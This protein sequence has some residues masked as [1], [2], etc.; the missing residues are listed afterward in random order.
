M[1]KLV[2]TR[3]RVEESE[4]GTNYWPEY[5]PE[6]RKLFGGTKL[7]WHCVTDMSPYYFGVAYRICGY[8]GSLKWAQEVIDKATKLREDDIK[9]KLHDQTKKAK[10]IKYP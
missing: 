7:V 4:Y 6:K 1:S 5:C 10:Y 3:I 8:R 2:G 9:R